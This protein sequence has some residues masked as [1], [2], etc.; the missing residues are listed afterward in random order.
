MYQVCKICAVSV[1]Y[2]SPTKLST[3][4]SMFANTALIP[5]R[6]HV[7][8]YGIRDICATLVHHNTEASQLIS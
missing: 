6:V 8:A 3:H 2:A 4:A 1:L 7:F 5:H